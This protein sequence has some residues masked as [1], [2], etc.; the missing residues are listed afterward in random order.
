M[1]AEALAAASVVYAI[2]VLATYFY[3]VRKTPGCKG[4]ILSC[5]EARELA[6]V[7]LIIAVQ[8]AVMALTA[9]LAS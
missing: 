2:A 1:I 3:L 9:L 4:Q 5:V 8:I 6:V 7:A